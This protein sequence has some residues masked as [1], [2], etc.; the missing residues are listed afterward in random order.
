MRIRY[1]VPLPFTNTAAIANRAQQIP[2]GILKAD[3]EVVC[4][5]IQN[6]IGTVVD[7]YYG[8]LVLDM[9][10]TEAGLRAEAEGFDAVVMDTASD[11]GLLP[12]RS[13]LKIPVLGPGIVSYAVG[14]ILGKR[15]SIITMFKGWEHLYEKNLDT[16][17]LWS[18]CASIRS[19]G[20]VPNVEALFAGKEQEMF[21]RLEEESV[22]AIN[23]DRADVILLGSTTMH[24]AGEYLS[25]HLPVPVVNPGPVAIKMAET[26]SELGLSHSKIAYPTPATLQ[27]EKFHSVLVAGQ[28][29]PSPLASTVPGPVR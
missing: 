3:T 9:Y 1:I 29:G 27:D 18:K 6:S 25:N 5:P 21:K 26:I 12:L 20:V 19:I 24:Q 11:A 7:S 8:D 17:G 2:H 14:I 22:K 10:L 13:R 23:D 28:P 15:F 4:V 16:Y